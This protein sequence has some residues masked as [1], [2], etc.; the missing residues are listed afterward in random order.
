MRRTLGL[1][2]VV[3][4]LALAGCDGDPEATPP[5]T[6]TSES[7]TSTIAT[8]PAGGPPVMPA[9]AREKSAAGAK[10]FVRYYVKVINDAYASGLTGALRNHSSTEC[11]PCLAVAHVIDDRSQEGGSQVGGEW[12]LKALSLG[13][14][15]SKRHHSFVVQIRQSSGRWRATKDSKPQPI[16]AGTSGFVFTTRW[17]DRRWRITQI[18]SP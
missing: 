17:T 12:T 9:L 5:P 18:E 10:A 6:P 1:G 4:L 7:P 8:E 2:I 13:P 11:A 3:G 15:E 16:R 14:S